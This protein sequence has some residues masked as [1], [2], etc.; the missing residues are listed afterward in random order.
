[1]N[2]I[3]ITNL[4]NFIG[5]YKFCV[6]FSFHKFVQKSHEFCIMVNMNDI[7]TYSIFKKIQ[8]DETFFFE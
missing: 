4:L 6:K 2:D 3:N 7:C 1:M 8:M 5:S